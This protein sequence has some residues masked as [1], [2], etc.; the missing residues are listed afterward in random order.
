M[1]LSFSNKILQE[2]F[3][4]LNDFPYLKTLKSAIEAVA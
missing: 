1:I 4:I 2:E 3:E